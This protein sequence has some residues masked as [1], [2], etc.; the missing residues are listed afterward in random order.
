MFYLKKSLG[1]VVFC[2][3]I[4][5]SSSPSLE[6]P[7]ITIPLSFTATIPLDPPSA[8]DSIYQ[9][10]KNRGELETPFLSQELPLLF[11]WSGFIF[12]PTEE[13]ALLITTPD[14]QDY[15]VDILSFVQGKWLPKTQLVVGG[16]PVAFACYLEDFNFDGIQDLFLQ[17]S[18]SNGYP[19]SRGHLI[20]VDKKTKKLTVVEKAK[21][22]GNL[23]VDS[24]QQMVLSEEVIWCEKDASRA[25]C[26]WYHRWEK[27]SLVLDRKECPCIPE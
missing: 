1:G 17:T 4:A 11:F 10:L 3:L 21:K 5:C 22:L 23:G 26:Q 14:G 13:E 2:L 25:A 16:N 18:I 7:S 9:F 20:L 8:A 12:S 6:A 15:Q 19:I 27:G 24:L